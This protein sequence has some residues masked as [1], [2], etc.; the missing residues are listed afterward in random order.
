M[1]PSLRM[2]PAA[3]PFVRFVVGPK[4]QPAHTLDGVFQFGDLP[5]HPPGWTA[6]D[7]EAVEEAYGWFNA[8]L[9]VPPL[10]KST[11]TGVLACWFR[12]DAGEMLC[13]TWELARKICNAGLPVRYV[14]TNHPGP[15]VY[16]D[17]H[18]VVARRPLSGR[19]RDC[20]WELTL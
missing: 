9:V 10:L 3:R 14:W 12:S 16:F 15:I 17:E 13:R 6:E 2:P 20:Y 19:R 5:D 11:R 8:H 7:D 1:P 18:Q 4:S